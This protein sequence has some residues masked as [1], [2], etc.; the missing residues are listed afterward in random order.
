LAAI[1]TGL[2][3]SLERLPARSRDLDASNLDQLPAAPNHFALCRRYKPC[4]YEGGQHCTCEA[5]GEHERL[6]KAEGI[7]G[8]QL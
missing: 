2:P 6:G 8:E 7:A 5:M 4:T 1:V 3:I